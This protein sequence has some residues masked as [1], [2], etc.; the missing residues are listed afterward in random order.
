[1]KGR[2]GAKEIWA[3]VL[4]SLIGRL[5]FL[6]PVTFVN[7]P[8]QSAWMMPL[9]ALPIGLF[10]LLLA[11]KLSAYGGPVCLRTARPGGG[12]G[13]RRHRIMGCLADIAD[14]NFGRQD[15]FGNTVLFFPADKYFA[16]S[17][18]VCGADVSDRL[19]RRG[20]HCAFGPTGLV[21]SLCGAAGAGGGQFAEY[22]LEQ[23]KPCHGRR[24]VA[25][26]AGGADVF[27]CVLDGAV[28][29]VLEP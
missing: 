5:V 3:S 27:H 21:Y 19:W 6:D 14:G 15:D 16:D 10:M 11:K 29:M 7:Q 18:V 12:P 17:A 13:P 28:R 2:I 22:G 9:I 4:V 1:M 24:A 23:R 25:Y 8:G 26:D 20:L